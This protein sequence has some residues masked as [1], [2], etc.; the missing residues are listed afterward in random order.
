MGL[1]GDLDT[2][3]AFNMNSAIALGFCRIDYLGCLASGLSYPVC[4]IFELLA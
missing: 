4:R 3:C 2:R 1:S